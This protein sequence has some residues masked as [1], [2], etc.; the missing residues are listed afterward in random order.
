MQ[1]AMI[2]HPGIFYFDMCH[3]SIFV[4]FISPPQIVWSF[5]VT[6]MSI[7]E[8]LITSVIR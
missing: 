6:I 7:S 1:I 5:R 3:S 4:S 2:L 8:L